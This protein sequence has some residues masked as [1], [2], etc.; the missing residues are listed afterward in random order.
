[1]GWG[2]TLVPVVGE[3]LQEGSFEG[4]GLWERCC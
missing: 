3:L 2:P 1:V 4:C